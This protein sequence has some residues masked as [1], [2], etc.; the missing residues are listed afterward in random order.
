M[1]D[2]PQKNW[3]APVVLWCL[4]EA[5]KS[6]E[7]IL[8]NGVKCSYLRQQDVGYRTSANPPR[9]FKWRLD[10]GVQTQRRWSTGS[11]VNCGSTVWCLSSKLVFMCC[12]ACF[13]LVIYNRNSESKNTGK[14]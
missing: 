4:H 2:F 9:L 13:S 14:N 12:Q 1:V 6:C 8:G 11:E 7:F 5:S 10:C 3:S